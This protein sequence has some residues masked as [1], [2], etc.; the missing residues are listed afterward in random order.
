M[1]FL[2]VYFQIMFG[3]FMQ[4]PPFADEQANTLRSLC[5]LWGELMIIDLDLVTPYH[6][7]TLKSMQFS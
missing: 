7:L 5:R 3:L 6:L 2:F 1:I 4:H